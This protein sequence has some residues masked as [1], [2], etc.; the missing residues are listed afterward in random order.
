MFSAH[1]PAGSR[2][3]Q[4]PPAADKVFEGQLFDVFQW[5]ERLYDGSEAL[6]EMAR[7][8]DNVIVIGVSADG[9]LLATS[10]SQPAISER[11]IDFP[12]GR[13]EPSETPAVAAVREMRE[14]TGFTSHELDLIFEFQPSDRVDSVTY[15][16]RATGLCQVDQP[17]PDRGE[18]TEVV[19]LS[20]AEVKKLAMENNRLALVP[21][22]LAGEVG[23]LLTGLWLPQ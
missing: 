16:F 2:R 1:R 10:Q 6:F 13:V 8:P 20:L 12:G 19:W 22:L 7:R 3:V 23:D 18:K 17:T 15:I 11:F 9:L 5:R 21:I 14:E 4:I